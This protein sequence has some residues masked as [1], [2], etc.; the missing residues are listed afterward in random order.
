MPSRAPR[1]CLEAGC[2]TVTT[3]RSGRCHAHEQ[4]RRAAYE[5]GRGTAAQRGYDAKWR[6]LRKRILLRDPV[7]RWVQRAT[8]GNL[9]YCRERS[10]D[11]AHLIPRPRG[12]DRPENLRGLCHRH[13][14]AETSA[15]E[16]WNAPTRD[17]SR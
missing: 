8:D 14:S 5:R 3:R 17:R 13:H 10:T 9:I 2:L 12:K 16:S 15:R 6:E 1:P 7:C 11:V 4:A